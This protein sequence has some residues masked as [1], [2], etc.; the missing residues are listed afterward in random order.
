IQNLCIGSKNH[1][2]IIRLQDISL[3]DEAG[4][5]CRPRTATRVGIQLTGAKNNQFEREE[6]RY[7]EKSGDATFCPVLAA[8]WI[9]KGTKEFNTRPEQ[10]ALSINNNRAI[11][12]KEATNVIK[13]A[14]EA[15]GMDFT[16]FMTHSVRF[17]GA[18]A[19]LNAGADKL[20]IKLPGRRMSSAYEGYPVLTS[21]ETS[22]MSRLMC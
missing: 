16:R 21:Q 17:G 1:G 3:Y 13:R 22:G 12:S 18:T 7:H 15:R 8:R 14:A 20:P 19:L 11:T 5:I 6:I 4:R 2:Y 9:F 10:P